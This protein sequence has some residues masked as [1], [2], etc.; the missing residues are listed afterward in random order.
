MASRAGQNIFREADYLP[1]HP[2]VPAKIPELKTEQ[3]GYK[4]VI[5]NPNEVDKDATR[6]AK[7]YEDVFR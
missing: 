1:M 5:Y 6:W 7:I 3:G 2:D 4:A